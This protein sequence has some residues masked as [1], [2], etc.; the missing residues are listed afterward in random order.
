MHAGVDLE[1]DLERARIRVGRKPVDLA[2]VMDRRLETEP[3]HLG[4]IGRLVDA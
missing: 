2:C 3:V 1:P 4:N